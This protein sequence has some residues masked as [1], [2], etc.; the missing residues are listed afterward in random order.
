[1]SPA[2]RHPLES[3][4]APDDRAHP[5]ARGDQRFV[6]IA[7]D[8]DGF[9]ATMRGILEHH[10][11]AVLEASDGRAALDQWKQHGARIGLV[12]SDVRMPALT[13][14]EFVAHVR[15]DRRDM[16]VVFMSGTETDGE[17]AH[18]ARIAG[19]RAPLLRKPFDADAL[20]DV[21]ARYW[22]AA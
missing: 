14:P 21:V 19:A 17:A 22:P 4:I 11:Y 6:L 3:R 2:A 12:V 9:R 10:G 8:D 7:D 20:T 15:A 1:V 5:T 18:V 13:G 16:P